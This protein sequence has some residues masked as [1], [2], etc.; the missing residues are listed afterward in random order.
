[1][2]L[3]V[4]T[5]FDPKTLEAI[6]Q[7]ILEVV[8][9]ADEGP[10]LLQGEFLD[11]ETIFLRLMDRRKKLLREAWYVKHNGTYVRTA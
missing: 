8:Q 4:D 3:Q 7:R 10:W 5:R 1:M 6:D 11:A 9:H 2:Q